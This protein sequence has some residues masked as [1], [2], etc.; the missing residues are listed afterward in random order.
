[1]ESSEST[2]RE[3]RAGRDGGQDPNDKMLMSNK[4]L[5]RFL[6]KDP[7]SFGISILIFGCAEMLMGFQLA[8]VHSMASIEMYYPFGEGALF[9][10]CG[11]LSICTNRHPS[12]RMVTACLALY[13]ASIL[14]FFVFLACRIVV[15]HWTLMMWYRS[16]TR[17]WPSSMFKVV[18]VRW[19]TNPPANTTLD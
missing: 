15:F 12:K 13:I 18:V 6:R 19:V 10:A 11:I 3:R 1:M 8:Y 9:A 17:D 5:H 14:A 16:H 2:A 7:T 4:P